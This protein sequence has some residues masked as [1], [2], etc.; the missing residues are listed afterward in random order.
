MCDV[1]MDPWVDDYD[2]RATR[3]SAEQAQ[4]FTRLDVIPNMALCNLHRK[5]IGPTTSG[6]VIVISDE[7]KGPFW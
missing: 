6:Q 5:M 1:G 2:R 7:I 3:R 4:G